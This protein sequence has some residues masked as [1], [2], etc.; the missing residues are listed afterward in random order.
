MEA[1]MAVVTGVLPAFRS[2]AIGGSRCGFQDGPGDTGISGG[3][4]G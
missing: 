2:A 1:A 3:S 4:T